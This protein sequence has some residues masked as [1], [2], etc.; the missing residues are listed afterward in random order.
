MYYGNS[1]YGLAT[2]FWFYGAVRRCKGKRKEKIKKKKMKKTKQKTK[3]AK[4]A[5]Q[6]VL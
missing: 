4:P 5:N 6:I 3:T 2:I 1:P